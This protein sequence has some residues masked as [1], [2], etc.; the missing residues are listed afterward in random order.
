MVLMGLTPVH[1][2][3]QLLVV[4]EEVQ[5]TTAILE[6]DQTEDPAV[7]QEALEMEL[8]DQAIRQLL[9]HI[10]KVMTEAM[11]RRIQAVVV[12]VAVLQAIQAVQVDME[13]RPA[14]EATDIHQILQDL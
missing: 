9:R 12:E 5:K 4:A 8:Q 10:L 2:V 13:T 6:M 3:I 14:P 7:V 11:M 1:L